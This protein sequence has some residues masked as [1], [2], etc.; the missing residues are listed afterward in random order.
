MDPIRVPLWR[1]TRAR[2]KKFKE[3]LNAFILRIL[4]GESSW[5]SK[6]KDKSVD[7]EWKIMVRALEWLKLQ[8]IAH[9]HLMLAHYRVVQGIGQH[10]RVLLR[11]HFCL[12]RLVAHRRVLIKHR[13]ASVS[14]LFWIL[15][16]FYIPFLVFWVSE[17]YFSLIIIFLS[18][19]SV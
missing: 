10:G 13:C 11:N 16:T 3:N 17:L 12:N 9:G 8:N 14:Y 7:Q 19:L 2:A 5:S 1:I 6:E 4:V 18:F 15:T